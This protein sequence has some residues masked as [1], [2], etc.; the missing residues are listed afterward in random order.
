MLVGRDPNPGLHPGLHPGLPPAIT[1]GVTP[2]VTGHFSGVTPRIAGVLSCWIPGTLAEILFARKVKPR[3]RE[4]PRAKDFFSRSE[5]ALC[6]C[7]AF[8]AARQLTLQRNGRLLCAIV[9]T[10]PCLLLRQVWRA[11]LATRYPGVAGN[12]AQVAVPLAVP[13]LTSKLG[14]PPPVTDF[15]RT[16]QV[17]NAFTASIAVMEFARILGQEITVHS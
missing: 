5:I 9:L 14:Y 10:P 3:E 2:W 4:S 7:A 11:N 15:V 6:Y 12:R 8:V 17:E 1:P 13:S 16:V